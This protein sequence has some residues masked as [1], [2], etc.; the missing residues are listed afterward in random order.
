[1]RK[2]LMVIVAALIITTLSAQPAP[3]RLQETTIAQIHAA[4]RDGS[5]TCRALVEQYLR[6]IEADDKDGAKLNAIVMVNPITIGRT[7]TATATMLTRGPAGR[8]R[9]WL[10]IAAT[11]NM[12]SF[13]LPSVAA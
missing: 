13:L 2:L 4:F 7:R 5:L 6:R 10:A 11:G 1:M 12:T 8:T 9:V 3:F